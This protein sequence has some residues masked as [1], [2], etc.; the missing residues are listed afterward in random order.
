[1]WGLLGFQGYHH[2]LHYQGFVGCWVQRFQMVL[3]VCTVYVGSHV[4]LGKFFGRIEHKFFCF[5][6]LKIQN[7]AQSYTIIST[8]FDEDFYKY[9]LLK[10]VVKTKSCY[11]SLFSL[12]FLSS[13]MFSIKVQGPYIFN[14]YLS[15]CR[16]PFAAC[17]ISFVY[18]VVNV[19]LH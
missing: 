7:T 1:M 15:P 16:W 18:E 5:F 17:S 11:R 8:N 9:Y 19:R 10:L 4:N 13:F 12:L 2:Y 14:I 3:R 6:V